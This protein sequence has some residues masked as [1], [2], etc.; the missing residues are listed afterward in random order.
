MTL[1]TLTKPATEPPVRLIAGAR[2]GTGGRTDAMTIDKVEFASM[3]CSRLCHDLLSPVGALNNG[4]ELMADE[5]DPEMRQRCIEL[6]VQSA[7]ISA[8]K[9]KYF[10]LAFGSAGGFDHE[11]PSSEAKAAI[12]GMIG[13]NG[14]IE[15]GWMVQNESLPKPVVKVLL[16]MALIG[17][18]SLVR[19]GRL[20]VGAE[21]TDG[22]TEIVVRAEGPRIA[23]DPEITRALQGEI[24]EIELSSRTAA[25][26]MTYAIADHHNG[27]VVVSV[28][29]DNAVLLGVMLEG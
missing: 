10:R 21:R 12:A 28:D 2:T 19:G 9:L 7:R 27:E 20:D 24:L 1:N 8:E 4:L 11:I 5:T 25:A 3:L 13:P 17:L 18:E 14:R 23:L 26:W 29:G 15:L 16:N 22:G 6:L